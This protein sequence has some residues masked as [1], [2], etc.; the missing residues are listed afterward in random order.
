MDFPKYWVTGKNSLS[1]GQN[2]GILC[3]IPGGLDK[4]CWVMMKIP[5]VMGKKPWVILKIGLELW[6]KFLELFENPEKKPCIILENL[7]V[8]TKCCYEM[9]YLDQGFF[10]GFS[11][12]SRKFFHNSS[13]IFLI[14]QGFLPIT[15]GIF[16]ITQGFFII[17]QGIFIITQQFLSKPQG[18]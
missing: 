17:T 9:A 15:Q 8:L 16:I 2:F 7:T 1:F 11:N 4:N 13:P 5:W 10:S 12:N 14:T 6:K 18:I 3:E